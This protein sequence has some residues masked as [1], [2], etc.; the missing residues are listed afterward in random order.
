VGVSGYDPNLQCGNGPVV[1]L[2]RMIRSMA[3]QGRVRPS[4]A[5]RWRNDLNIHVVQAPRLMFTPSILRVD[6]IAI[7]S[8]HTLG[9][10]DEFNRPVFRSLQ[11]V[12]GHFYI[13]EFSRRLIETFAGPQNKPHVVIHNSV[14]LREFHPEGS[15]YRGD[16]GWSGTDLVFVASAKWRRW[17]RLP[18]T[19][20]WFRRFKTRY[21]GVCRLLILGGGEH[22]PTADPDVVYAG[23][24]LPGELP[25]WYRTGDVFVHLATLEACGNTQI[26]A[27][28]CGLPVLCAPN[29]GIRETVE[30]AS[31]GLVSECDPPYDFTLVD[32]YHPPA[33][34]YEVL[35]RDSETLVA[36]LDAY[37]ARLDRSA[38]DIHTAAARL[39]DFCDLIL[40]T[41]AGLR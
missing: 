37:R 32:H 40:K 22:V 30:K 25:S 13:S 23:E 38:L 16:L 15:D 21:D 11:Q 5:S 24:H 28:A 41:K 1:S 18:E 14:D 2:N 36:E 10:T 12:D 3:E 39:A 9:N 34:D 33:P 6:G 27:M 8:G 35:L 4:Q 31:G 29:G 17:K 19:L 7:D 20:E 26:E